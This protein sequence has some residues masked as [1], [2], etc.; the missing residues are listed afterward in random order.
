MR[1]IKAP[2]L[3]VDP[4]R[5]EDITTAWANPLITNQLHNSHIET[6]T[7]IC[8][9]RFEWD[10]VHGISSAQDERYFADRGIAGH[11]VIQRVA[12]G[13][14]DIVDMCTQEWEATVSK[15][16]PLEMREQESMHY[17]RWAQD[18]IAANAWLRTHLDL[19]NVHA[20]K[21][22]VI[23]KLSDIVPGISDK[24]S[25]AGR[26]DLATFGNSRASIYDLKFRDRLNTENNK[27]S[28][29]PMSY[30]LAAQYYGFM[31]EFKFIEVVRGSVSEQT[32]DLSAQRLEFFFQ[33]IRDAV[34]MIELGF[35]PMNTGGWHCSRKYCRAFQV[36]RGAYEPE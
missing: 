28:V 23:P 35:F 36:C 31:P 26:F 30:G 2:Y 19:T 3:G 13:E 20:E 8:A 4:E 33:R 18:V 7:S 25:Y 1:E 12:E 10:F 27:R 5:P 22:F 9:K 14:A 11:K 17:A 15:S 34:E 32:I 16:V 29:Q 24:W 21:P 6:L